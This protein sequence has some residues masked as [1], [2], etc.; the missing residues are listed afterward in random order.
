[1]KVFFAFF[2]VSIA[3]FGGYHLSFRRISG[4]SRFVWL[5]LTGLE[6]LV[7]GLLLGPGFLNVL[8][9]PTV[10]S[11]EP[12]SA[13]ALG[14][15]GLLLGF[16]F[17]ISQ[18][19]RFPP[20]F[21]LAS[22]MESAV[23]VLFSFLFLYFML[24][25]FIPVSGNLHLVTSLALSAAAACT[26]QSVLALVFPGRPG[27]RV[28]RSLRLLRY[29]GSLDGLVPMLILVFIFF[30][31]SRQVTAGIL[32]TV[33][34]PGAVLAAVFVIY[35]FFLTQRRDIDEL[36][37]VIIG[38]TVLTSGAAA[39]AGFSSLLSNFF[40]GLCLV[41]IT[42][43]KEKIFHLLASIEKPVYLVLLIFL[44]A[45]WHLPDLWIA[46]PAAA[47]W[48]VRIFG[49]IAGGMAAVSSLPALHGYPRILG[50][51]LIEQG[52]LA[53]AILFEFQ[54]RF[55]GQETS[56]AVGFA[57]VAIVMAQLASPYFASL[58]LKRSD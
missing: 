56:Y 49:K 55:S 57:L 5:H 42:M 37:L 34:L 32:E 41:N 47:Y 46:L 15:I 39:M 3:A 36:A 28:S 50:L 26:A 43:E 16:Q 18:L 23:T 33:L 17:E 12:F 1:M 45:G 14:W 27:G 21:F 20:A 10:R 22:L 13:L 25:V 6:F 58:V 48:L 7:I 8:D 54:Q 19:R 52:G 9:A 53:V 40:M 4:S 31:R 30:V 24:P 44:G 2:L 38:M 29:I 51:G 35:V 11:L